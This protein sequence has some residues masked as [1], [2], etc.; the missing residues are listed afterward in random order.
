MGHD[1]SKWITFKEPKQITHISTPFPHPLVIDLPSIIPD[2]ACKIALTV[3]T[4]SGNEPPSASYFYTF[5]TE[6]NGEPFYHHTFM[7][8]Y[9]QVLILNSISS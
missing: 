4:R 9:P 1:K 3:F 7:F 5:S 2:N 8:S 6:V